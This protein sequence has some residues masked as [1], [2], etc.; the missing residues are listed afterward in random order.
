MNTTLRFLSS[1]TAFIPLESASPVLEAGVEPVVSVLVVMP[2]GPVVEAEAAVLTDVPKPDIGIALPTPLLVHWAGIVMV[3]VFGFR[4]AALPEYILPCVSF[5]RVNSP[6][7]KF[8]VD[9][10]AAV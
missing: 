7:N 9:P 2:E 6:V 3:A 5:A 8:A 4:L 10:S 1:A